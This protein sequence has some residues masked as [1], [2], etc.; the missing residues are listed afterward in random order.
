MISMKFFLITTFFLSTTALAN[1]FESRVI[2][3]ANAKATPQ[4]TQYHESMRP[5]ISAAI[6]TCVPPDTTAPSS[7]GNFT[8]VGYVSRAGKIFLVD[9][10]PKTAVAMCFAAQLVKMH[11]TS[12]PPPPASQA[13]FPIAVKMSVR[14]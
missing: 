14:M 10:Q 1:D 6:G 8:L 7:A 5:A 3:A 4:G 13:G 12:P 11:L 2:A 9:V